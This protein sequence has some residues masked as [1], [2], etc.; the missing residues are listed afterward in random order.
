MKTL[1]DQEARGGILSRLER[2][3]AESR[4]HWG[5]MNVEQM[6]THLVASMR[7]ACGELETKSKNLPIRFP[8]LRQLVVYWLPW[9]KGSPTAPELLPSDALAIEE[10]K[11]ELMRLVKIVGERAAAKQW[12]QHP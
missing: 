12:P 1:F 4:P 5:K 11:R 8:P 2:V 3:S 10:S 7:M 9:P 6:L